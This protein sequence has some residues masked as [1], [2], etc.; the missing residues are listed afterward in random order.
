MLR[1][2]SSS[3]AATPLLV[4]LVLLVLT[5]WCVAQTAGPVFSTQSPVSGVMSNKFVVLLPIVNSGSGTA[6]NVTVNSVALSATAPLLPA[7]PVSVGTLNAGDHKVVNLQFDSSRLTLGSNY[8]LTVRGTY[9]TNGKTLGFAV[10]RFV[11]PTVSGA[12][13]TT[14]LRR[15][16]TLDAIKDFCD[17][18]PGTDPMNDRAAI[19]GFLKSRP[20]IVSTGGFGTSVWGHFANGE[21]AV[22]GNDGRIASSSTSANAIAASSEAEFLEA[23]QRAEA[24]SGRFQPPAGLAPRDTG[25]QPPIDL[26]GSSNVRLFTSLTGLG[27][28]DLMTVTTLTGF[29]SQAHYTPVGGT[30]PTIEALKKV[31]GDGVF[32]LTTHGDILGGVESDENVYYGLWTATPAD[33]QND[34]ANAGDIFLTRPP[35]LIHVLETSGADPITRKLVQEWRYS[36]TPAFVRKYWQKFSTGS[37]IYIDACQSDNAD[38]LRSAIFEKNG[39]VYAGWTANADD[40]FAAKTALLLFDRL[41]GANQVFLEKGPPQRPF[42]WTQAQGD[43]ALHLG[44]GPSG[45]QL[46][47]TTGTSNTQFGILAPSIGYVLL[48]ETTKQIIIQGSFGANP[49]SGGKVTI[50]NTKVADADLNWSDP[51]NLV[52]NR[53]DPSLVGDVTVEV[54]G[55]KSNVARITK[56]EGDF[57]YAMQ[58]D[59]SLAQS[60]KMHTAFRVDARQWRP[61]IHMLPVE[62]AGPIYGQMVPISFATYAC[63]GTNTFSLEPHETQTQTWTGSG[64]IAGVAIEPLVPPP[65]GNFFTVQGGVFSHTSIQLSMSL[66]QTTGPCNEHVHDVVTTSSGSQSS[67]FD[68]PLLL[69]YGTTFVALALDKSAVIQPDH[70]PT[71]NSCGMGSATFEWS[72]ISPSANTAPNPSSAR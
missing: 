36:I 5:P 12:D 15:W 30:T 26:P 51:A 6:D 13:V 49:G 21:I 64:S 25:S 53:S 69:C 42:D 29:L 52:V 33:F 32:Y 38:D 16:V 2:R 3:V 65:G 70:A 14:V 9:Q 54:R 43:I 27:T 72:S 35:P 62:P 59:G 19:L 28:V 47:F 46:N 7:I 58:G 8:L 31:G 10:N 18:L 40:R 63:S 20:E 60:Y 1:S 61:L 24:P 66:D 68:N 22:I 17:S 48:L 71:V 44:N 23:A 11:Q 56:W 37:F 50:G 34:V 55:H 67:D 45:E 57:V 39:S 41:L 4:T